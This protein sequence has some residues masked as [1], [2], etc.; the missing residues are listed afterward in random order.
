MYCLIPLSVLTTSP[1]NLVVSTLILV[2]VRAHNFY[3][4]SSYSIPNTAGA[5]VETIPSQMSAPYQDAATSNVQIVVD[6]ASVSTSPANGGSAIIS[7]G[8]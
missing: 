2:E 6:W 3:G 8:V 5:H 7:Y 1:Y 4:W